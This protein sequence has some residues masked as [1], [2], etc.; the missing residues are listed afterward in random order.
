VTDVLSVHEHVAAL[1]NGLRLTSK[2]LRL[3]QAQQGFGFLA[4]E[5]PVVAACEF[6]LLV[7]VVD[8]GAGAVTALAALGGAVPLVTPLRGES[9]AACGAPRRYGS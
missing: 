2:N 5:S 6:D 4:D 8:F 9:S 3:G 7:E 1:V